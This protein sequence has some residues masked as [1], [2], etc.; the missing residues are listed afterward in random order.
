M[1]SLTLFWGLLASTIALPGGP[2]AGMDYLAYDVATGRLWVPAGNTGNVDVVDT[3]TGKLT[4]IGGFATAPS[5][6]PGRPNMGPS[7]AT[8]ANGVVWIGNRGDNQVCSF[9]AKS[10]AKQTCVHL[11]SMPDGLAY[12]ATTR[13]VWVTTPRDHTLTIIDV[14]GKAP[15]VVASLK[16]D[17]A[18]EGYAVDAARGLF[19]TNL[20]DKD[21][22]L[23]VD[24]KQRAVTKTWPTTCGG[25]GPRG[26]SLD[27]ANGH[28]FVACTDGAVTLD[29]AHDGKAVGRL[30][31]GGGVDNIDF[32]AGKQLLFVASPRDG[33]LT[34][35]HVTKTGALGVQSAS[36]TA[37]GARNAVIDGK[38][39]AYVPDSA[40]GTLII[41]P[42]SWR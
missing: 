34:I 39:V 40:G 26:L 37:K 14:A 6:R 20:E 18:P 32:L 41:V 22:T 23:T 36:P 29:L 19:Y 42:P 28:L 3:T 13:E 38:G 24:V 31:T 10:L 27:A 25:D 8:V 9:D 5:P 2:P 16:V 15:K 7:S 35:A 21:V 12:V 33:T 1:I 4:P 11:A 30:K 17:G